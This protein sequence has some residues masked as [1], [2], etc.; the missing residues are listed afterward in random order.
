MKVSSAIHEKLIKHKEFK[1]PKPSKRK[2]K[3]N[4]EKIQDVVSRD[5]INKREEIKHEIEEMDN[6]EMMEVDEYKYENNDMRVSLLAKQV[7]KN[8]KEQKNAFKDDDHNQ[9]DFDKE[10]NALL[11]GSNH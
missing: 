3:D 10:W 2:N 1:H 6:V 11:N 4:K 9:S 7:A 8:R 5:I